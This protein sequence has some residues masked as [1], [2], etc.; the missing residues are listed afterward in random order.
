MRPGETILIVLR[1]EPEGKARPRFRVISPKD[2]KKRPFA[3]VYTPKATQTYETALKLAANV[4]MA[5]RPI[6]VGPLDVAIVAVMEIPKSWSRKKR[7]AAFAG[8]LWPTVTPDWDNIA[9]MLDAL[10]GTVWVDDKQ[11]VRGRVE[12]RY[13]AEPRLEV[14][15]SRLADEPGLV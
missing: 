7:E 9:K 11:V 12:K 6:L 2:R 10:N 5:G 13:G 15:V 4:A 14:A 8:T 1:G 3:S